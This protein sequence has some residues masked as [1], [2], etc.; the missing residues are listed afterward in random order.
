METRTTSGYFSGFSILSLVVAIGY[1]CV[2]LI[3]WWLTRKNAIIVFGVAMFF[4]GVANSLSCRV[5]DRMEVAGYEVGHWRWFTKDLK[6]YSEYW[7]IAPDKGWSR[8]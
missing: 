2:C 3:F 1:L 5:L 8:F 4:G 6:L 7:R